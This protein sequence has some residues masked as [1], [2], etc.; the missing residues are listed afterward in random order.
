MELAGLKDVVR[1]SINVLS[2]VLIWVDL[3]FEEIDLRQES[4]ID[5]MLTFYSTPPGLFAFFN[6]LVTYSS[7]SV[8]PPPVSKT[9]E[10]R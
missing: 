9:F 10:R 5:E 1:V 3:S 8:L 2:L 7:S 6:F 4:M